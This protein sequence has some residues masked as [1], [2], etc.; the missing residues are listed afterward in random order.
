M[1]VF[2]FFSSHASSRLSKPGSCRCRVEWVGLVRLVNKYSPRPPC[3]CGGL[4][5][6]CDE[7]AHSVGR[8]PNIPSAAQRVQLEELRKARPGGQGGKRSRKRRKRRVASSRENPNPSSVFRA[9]ENLC[10]RHG[11]VFGIARARR[12][13]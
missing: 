3:C 1:C 4:A 10:A 12:N 6:L 7:P 2:Y 9:S 5:G 11:K 8:G 13:I